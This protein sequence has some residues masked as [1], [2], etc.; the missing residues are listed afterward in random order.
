MKKIFNN[1]YLDID[2]T[3]LLTEYLLKNKYISKYFDNEPIKYE[4][5]KDFYSKYTLTGIKK[6]L[7]LLT[8]YENVDFVRINYSYDDFYNM[9]FFESGE[10]IIWDE[11][12]IKDAL[13]LIQMNYKK[14]KYNF[15]KKYKFKV[16]MGLFKEILLNSYIPH[17]KKYWYKD[18]QEN[19]VN[20][21]NKY[22]IEKTELNQSIM[23]IYQT[24][25]LYFYQTTISLMNGIACNADFYTNIF[26]ENST[27]TSVNAIENNIDDI[28]YICKLELPKELNIL[29][30][31]QTLLDVINYR[32]SPYII[33]FRNIFQEWMNYIEK[34]E[35]NIAKKI[36]KDVIK[37]NG[38]FQKLD[39]FEKISNNPFIR[40][41]LFAGGFI[42][43]I[44]EMI[45]ISTYAGGFIKD[46]LSRKN[47]WVLISNNKK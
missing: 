24:M 43:I 9:G 40:T 16:E 46:G 21:A 33:S 37:A 25:L 10:K 17:I 35:I 31:P 38:Y 3:S 29:P 13:I 23:D 39:R 22:I 5:R 12:T 18:V 26:D 36:E 8:L 20:L 30:A 14:L 2:K 47:N 28:Y 4:L 27:V 15:E 42:P 32:K 45:N 7:I 6:L 44:S 1:L 19:Y 11:Q 41:C 34:G